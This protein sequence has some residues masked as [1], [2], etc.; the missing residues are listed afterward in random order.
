M[1]QPS[2]QKNWS[3]QVDDLITEALERIGGKFTSAE[4]VD[5]CMRSLNLVLKDL[6]N[7][8]K[9]L[10]TIEQK[11]L[12]IASS[13]RDYT[14]SAG[15]NAIL[16]PVIRVSGMDI[17]MNRIS[18]LDYQNIA[19]KESTGRPTQYTTT[20]GL[21][22]LTMKIWPTPTSVQSEAGAQIVYYAV[23]DPDDITAMYQGVDINRRYLP[24][25]TAGLA[26]YM[27]QKIPQFDINK[28]GFLKA[29]WNEQLRLAFEEDRE[30][31]SYVVRPASQINVW[32]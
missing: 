19:T 16:G 25:V 8:G 6:M 1:V 9:P 32:R 14:L 10:F 23:E 18:F 3:L 12:T 4:E 29:E 7:R 26:F 31:T 5:S 13:V 20:Q 30:L 11:S 22:N 28:L 24:C 2:G 27:A 17:P 21:N 15:T